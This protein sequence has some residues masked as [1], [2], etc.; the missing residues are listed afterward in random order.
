MVARAARAGP[1]S[2]TCAARQEHRPPPTVCEEAKCTNLGRKCWNNCTATIM[3]MGF[4]LCT[5]RLHSFGASSEHGKPGTA[6]SIP[7]RP[8]ERGALGRVMRPQVN[9]VLHVPSISTP[10]GRV[11]SRALRCVHRAIQ[12]AHAGRRRFFESAPA[13]FFQGVMRRPA[14]RCSTSGLE[15]V[16]AKRRNGRRTYAFQCAIRRG[17]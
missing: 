3:L 13:R 4:A 9:I 11:R 10:A 2:N 12:G 15:V 17:L 1:G 14:R 7:R 8:L 16:R 6:G 5:A